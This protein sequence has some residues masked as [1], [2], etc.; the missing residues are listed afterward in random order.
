M[1]RQFRLS[2]M[3][4]LSAKLPRADRLPVHTAGSAATGV[5]QRPPLVMVIEPRRPSSY[6]VHEDCSF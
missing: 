2:Q 6:A 5:A 4:E 1:I 3:E